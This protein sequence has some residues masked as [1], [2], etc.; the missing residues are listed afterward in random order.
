MSKN[1]EFNELTNAVKRSLPD[2]KTNSDNII[3]EDKKTIEWHILR[4]EV[5]KLRPL[6]V[7]YNHAWIM[8][9]LPVMVKITREEK[10]DIEYN[11]HPFFISSSKNLWNVMMKKPRGFQISE[12]IPGEQV[13]WDPIDALTYLKDTHKVDL[14]VVFGRI[15]SKVKG[16][17]ELKNEHYLNVY[18][19]WSI[20]TY[21]YRLFEY[22]PYLDFSGPKGSGKTK[23]VTI[24]AQ[25][26]YN[27]R[28]AHRITGANWARTVESLCC[29]TLIDEQED[30]LD[31]KSEHLQSMLT[32]LNSAF[33]TSAM[34]PITIPTKDGRWQ[35]KNFDIGVPVALAHINSI[36]E[37]T[38]DRTIPIMMITST[39]RKI[40][41]M[42]VK[43]DD[44]EWQSIR[45]LLYRS[46]LDHFKEVIQIRSEPIGLDNIS[47]RERNQ[48]WKPLITLARLFERHGII[49][50]EK[51]IEN[52]VEEIHHIKTTQ[53]QS[54]NKETLILE[55]LSNAII[56]KKITP[57]SEEND[58][59]YQ[60]QD[61]LNLVQQN[62][63]LQYMSLKEL[64]SVLS[65]L[66]FE[67]KKKNPYNMCVFVTG[68]ILINLSKKYNLE[69]SALEAQLAHVDLKDQG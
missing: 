30:L 17:V 68:E 54:E 64:G 38:A 3:Q 41:D 22:Y 47:A 57:I 60:Q 21:F 1:D 40:A 4:K 14:K 58:N 7:Q 18:V 66:Q 16:L 6:S 29:T 33:R 27:A 48:L 69:F 39:N 37:V 24:L 13:R 61:I 55:I 49:G 10:T 62:V 19:L 35:S 9:Y 65:R 15:H 12:V 8:T 11:N 23:A 32:L 44:K 46:F 50:L 25:L 31:P 26:C 45:N 42:E 5:K 2:E 36:N 53:N 52:I 56:E 63:D 43:E 20:G 51:S 28:L 59:W 34:V 67:R